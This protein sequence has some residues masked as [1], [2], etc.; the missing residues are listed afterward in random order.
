MVDSFLQPPPEPLDIK[1]T[2]RS[3]YDAQGR[4]A[5][6]IVFAGN[7]LPKYLWD[8]WSEQLRKMGFKWQDI[9]RSLSRNS[10]K[11]LSWISGE[12]SWREFIEALTEDLLSRTWELEGGRRTVIRK[13]RTLTDFL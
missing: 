1:K 3:L 10:D 7:Q 6:Y 8:H 5:K 4:R 2:L 12:I 11:A 13:T 9:L